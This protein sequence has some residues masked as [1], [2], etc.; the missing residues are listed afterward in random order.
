MLSALSASLKKQ[1]RETEEQ[2]NKRIVNQR[3]GSYFMIEKLEEMK[4]KQKVE[5]EGMNIQ[6]QDDDQISI[7]KNSANWD[8]SQQT[9]SDAVK[10]QSSGEKSEDDDEHV[11]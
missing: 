1:V 9:Q 11:V 8:E 2:I 7:P 4:E 5:E 10:S 3:R 6:A